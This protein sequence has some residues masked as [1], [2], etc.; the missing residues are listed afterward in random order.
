MAYHSGD[1][2]FASYLAC[3][4][5]L[6]KYVTPII[7][8][9]V[10]AEDIVQEVFIRFHQKHSAVSKSARAYLFRIAHN[11]A[12]DWVRKKKLE[13][14]LNVQDLSQWMQPQEV[15]TPERSILA[16]DELRRI[17]E[18]LDAC[19]PDHRIAVEMYR[20]GGCTM[21]QIAEHLGVSVSSVH[22]ML[23][24]TMAALADLMDQDD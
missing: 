15:V 18:F 12:L 17:S 8:S 20:F 14:G 4:S 21:E 9:R 11:L 19:P 24:K 5:A 1:G 23:R 10:D 22:R 2:Q 13:S 3:R 7:G 16:K 6:I